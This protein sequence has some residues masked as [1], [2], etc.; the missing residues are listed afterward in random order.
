MTEKQL[1]FLSKYDF[2]KNLIFIWDVWVWKT[3]QARKLLNR[4]SGLKYEIND[5]R[6]KEFLWSWLL[7]FKKPEERQSSMT[8]FP[9]EMMLRSKVLL[10]DDI[11]VSDVT[12]AYLRKLTFVLD[13]RIAKKLPTIFTSNLS[14]KELEMKLDKRIKSRV[15]L[16]ACIIKME[17]EDRR[18]NNIQII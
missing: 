15:F 11:W 4:Y 10:F 12:E 17:G 1:D 9:L 16:N 14:P 5:W 13:E 2:D 3:F 6:F 18:K 8:N 7:R